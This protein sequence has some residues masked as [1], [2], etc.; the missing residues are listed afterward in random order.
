M[1]SKKLQDANPSAP[2]KPEGAKPNFS[3]EVPGQLAVSN[4][5]APDPSK[6]HV[7]REIERKEKNAKVVGRTDSGRKLV[8]DV[9]AEA[10][11][12]EEG[13]VRIVE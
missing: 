3:A 10:V 4:L 1:D 5:P 13:Y 2:Q 7:A 9:G 12:G 6:D 11:A 8:E